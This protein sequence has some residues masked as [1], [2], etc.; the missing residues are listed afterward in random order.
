MAKKGKG[1]VQERLQGHKTRLST[2]VLLIFSQF[3]MWQIESSFDEIKYLCQKI[4][5]GQNPNQCTKYGHP[6]E[7]Y[8]AL[9]Y[10]L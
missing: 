5:H 9:F 7:I 8:W 6:I 3:Q 4:I 2:T 1:K 10:L